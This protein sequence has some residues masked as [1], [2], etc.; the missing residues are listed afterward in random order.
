MNEFS[1]WVVVDFEATCSDDSAVPRE[2]MEIIEFGAVMV[3]APSFHVV[4]E[5]QTFVKPKRNP[6]LTPFCKSLTSIGQ[7]D[8]DAAPRFSLALLQFKKWLSSF[9]TPLFSSW[10]DYDRK[11][12]QRDCRYH[13]VGYPFDTGHVNLNAAFSSA[14]RTRKMG[15][16]QALDSV[17]LPFLG[18]HHRGLDDARNIASLLPIIYPDLAQS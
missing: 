8:V 6:T 7:T 3:E 11:Q 1:H 17:G 2:Q 13:S 16:R 14:R 5:F 9:D 10:G 4:D 15:L 12:L 18:T